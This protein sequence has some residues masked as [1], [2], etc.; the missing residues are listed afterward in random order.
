MN[1][2]LVLSTVLACAG[3]EEKENFV[4][5]GNRRALFCKSGD[6]EY[7]LFNERKNWP[8]AVLQCEEEGMEIAEVRTIEEA[9]KLAQMMMR[10]RPDAIESAW[11][12][13][14]A[15]NKSQG[16]TWRWISTNEEISETLWRG[17]QRVIKNSSSRGCLLFDWHHREVPRFLE[18]PCDRRREYICQRSTNAPGPSQSER[19]IIHQEKTWRSPGEIITSRTTY[20][21]SSTIKS[22]I[23]EN[24]SPKSTAKIPVTPKMRNRIQTTPVNDLEDEDYYDSDEWTALETTTGIIQRSSEKERLPVESKSIYASSEERNMVPSL[25]LYY[26][27]E[28][29]IIGVLNGP[30]SSRKYQKYIAIKKNPT[31]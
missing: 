9:K 3:F 8:E 19:P 25:K 22:S 30:N 7:W 26:A 17:P 20:T 4:V 21:V 23:L 11:I 1:L 24:E 14:Y 12:G 27:F 6:N 31:N 18:F 28:G 5:I 13:G 15:K 10:N 2:I 16:M 29:P